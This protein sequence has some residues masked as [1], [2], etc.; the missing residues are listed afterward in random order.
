MRAQ[1][2][3]FIAG[4]EILLRLA[5]LA[6]PV[7]AL[8]RAW[9]EF[10]GGPGRGGSLYWLQLETLAAFPLF[11]WFVTR[12]EPLPS[13]ARR[14]V[15]RLPL[16]AWLSAPFLPGGGRGVLLVLIHLV[17][18]DLVAWYVSRQYTGSQEV[19]LQALR[20]MWVLEGTTLILLAVPSGIAS[21]WSGR[22]MVRISTLVLILGTAALLVFPPPW[23]PGW[24][25]LP[26]WLFWYIG[27]RP[28]LPLDG[29]VSTSAPWYTSDGEASF[30]AWQHLKQSIQW[31]LNIGCLLAVS[32]NLPRVGRGLRELTREPAR[33]P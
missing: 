33:G 14:W 16:W 11:A 12:P 28:P 7:A 22:R 2:Q 3:K 6:L 20:R 25:G 24:R 13:V 26:A 5:S 1:V 18:R 32:L 29:T 8:G 30:L 31:S 27:P 4:F 9:Q 19:D 21:R 15:P 17:G 23:L 10:G